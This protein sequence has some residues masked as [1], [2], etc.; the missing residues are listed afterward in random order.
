MNLESA[1]LM[2]V[3]SE[4]YSLTRQERESQE[5][6]SRQTKAI[7]KYSAKIMTAKLLTGMPLKDKVLAIK[8][9]AQLPHLM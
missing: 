7:K 9:G 3:S 5:C 6:G 1:L 2:E 4:G 8:V